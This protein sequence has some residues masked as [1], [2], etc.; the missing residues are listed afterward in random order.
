MCTL[1]LVFQN[2]FEKKK[3]VSLRNYQNVTFSNLPVLYVFYFLYTRLA[4]S[5]TNTRLASYFG[6]KYRVSF[7]SVPPV[8]LCTRA[9]TRLMQFGTIVFDDQKCTIYMKC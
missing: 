6:P 8:V 3:R 2:S 9:E 5:G 7:A 1:W 4:V